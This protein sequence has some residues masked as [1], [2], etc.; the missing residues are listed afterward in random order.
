MKKNLKELLTQKLAENT[1]NHIE[2][3]QVSIVDFGKK[4]VKIHVDDIDPNP[5]QPRKV[6]DHNEIDALA[7]SIA[8]TGLLQP[9]IVRENDGRYQIIAG[10]RRWRAH[11]IIGKTTVEAIITSAQ[12]NDMALSALVENLV[13]EN[14]S[15]YEIGKSLRQIENLFNTKKK[16]AQAVGMDRADMYAY[17]SFESLPESILAKLEKNPTL[18]SRTAAKELK[19]IVQSNSDNPNLLSIFDEA[20]NLL[21]QGLLK[22]GKL[23]TYISKKLN[24]IEFINSPLNRGQKLTLSKSGEAIGT[25][26]RSNQGLII[27]I[28]ANTLSDAIEKNIMTLLKGILEYE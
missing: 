20:I 21:E 28:N 10:E 11:K 15:D 7:Q 22:Q 2:S 9:I 14:L 16:L 25:I 19:T 6:F 12:D 5:Y 17:F 23:A 27:R 4:H 3:Q 1:K 13:R 24:D 8:E 18:L 26:T